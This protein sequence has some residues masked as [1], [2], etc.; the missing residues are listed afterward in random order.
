VFALVSLDY[1][2]TVLTGKKKES[3][4]PDDQWDKMQTPPEMVNKN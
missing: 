4:I 1:L 3:F 2:F